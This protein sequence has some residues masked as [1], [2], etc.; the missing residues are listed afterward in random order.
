MK[1]VSLEIFSREIGKRSELKKKRKEGF[2]PVE[3]YGKDVENFHGYIR[4]RD[5]EKLIEEGGT[6]LI[7]VEAN[8]KRRVCVLKDIQYGWLGDNPIHIDLYDISNVKD[9]EVEVP[10]EFV[11]TPAGVTEG[12]TF[13]PIM[14]TLTIKAPPQ[15][16]PEKIPVDVSGLGLGDSIHVNDIEAPKGCKIMD[17][18]DET[19]AVVLEVEEEVTTTEET[20]AE[21]QQTA[22]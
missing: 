4:A 11:G 14:H 15:N 13:E 18:P 19:V 6:F 16:I 21:E 2:I 3:I 20:T 10:I 17:S 8:G 22:T 5:L 7:E 12:G 1:K 9:L